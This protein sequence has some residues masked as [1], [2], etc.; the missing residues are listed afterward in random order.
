MEVTSLVTQ[1]MW[2]G[3]KLTTSFIYPLILGRGYHIG[4]LHF[5]VTKRQSGPGIDSVFGQLTEAESKLQTH[6]D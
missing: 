4:S 3:Q 6:C 5:L 1:E 2:R